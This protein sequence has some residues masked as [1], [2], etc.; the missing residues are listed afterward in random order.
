L[1]VLDGEQVIFAGAMLQ[2]TESNL[3]FNDNSFDEGDDVFYEL[4]LVS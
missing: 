3:E 2:K 4:T 1:F